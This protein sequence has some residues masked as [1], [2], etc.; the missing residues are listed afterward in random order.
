MKE[1]G[2]WLFENN[3]FG[4]NDLTRGVSRDKFGIHDSVKFPIPGIRG[5]PLYMGK[6]FK[7]ISGERSEA[8]AKFCLSQMEH[9]ITMIRSRVNF[10]QALFGYFLVLSKSNLFNK[11]RTRTFWSFQKVAIL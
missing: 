3:H 11:N 8:C 5:A 2:A 6:G 1:N 4:E 9:C 10:A 7:K